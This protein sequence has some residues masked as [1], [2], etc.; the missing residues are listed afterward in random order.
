MNYT[1][2]ITT[3]IEADTKKF[4]RDIDAAG[5]SAK[6]YGRDAK[7]A[8]NDSASAFRKSSKGIGQGLAAINGPLGGISGRFNALSGII[9][10]NSFAWVGF[11][12]A[13]AGA[14]TLLGAATAEFARVERQQLKTQAIL[15]ATGHAVGFS[16][17]E[18]DNQARAIALA[19][20]AST[21]G[22]R[23]AQNALLTFKSVQGSVF[24]ETIKLSQDLADSGFG[25]LKTNAIGLGKAL[26]DP[27][28][29]LTLLTKQGSLTKA[30]QKAI[31]DE[32]KR[33]GDLAAAQATILEAIRKQVGGA[34]GAA[35]GGL[36]GAVDTLGQRWGEM[37]EALADRTGI[38][39]ATTEWLSE[40]AAG[41][42]VLNK[43][44]A[45][46]DT[47]AQLNKLFSDRLAL[48][49]EIAR[50]EERGDARSIAQA[51]RLKKESAV[52]AT[53]LQETGE[54]QEKAR[55]KEFKEYERGQAEKKRLAA[56]AKAA[57]EKELAEAAA[58]EKA[59]Q[60]IQDQRIVDLAKVRFQKIHEEA[61][62]A[63]DRMVQLE[64]ARF[65]T[66]NAKLEADIQKIRDST[67]LKESVKA[68]IEAEYQTRKEERK[69]T[70]EQK[71]AEI[72]KKARDKKISEEAKANSNL[73]RISKNL[74]DS[75]I[76][77]ENKFVATAVKM[78]GILFDVKK[79]EAIKT[80]TMD[81]K[82]AI[83][84]AWASAA[85]PY[86]VPA[87]AL[88]T[89]QTAA[90]IAGIAGIAHGGL[91]NVPAESTFLLQKGER[92]LSPNQN[93]DFTDT[94]KN[95]GL[96]GAPNIN[97]HNYSG[98]P[99]EQQQNG[100][101]IDIFIGRARD[102][103]INDV[104]RGRGLGAAMQERYGLKRKGVA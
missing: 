36:S 9:H 11:G 31:G 15:N 21:E 16:A 1:G 48:Q 58:K 51:G 60:L 3:L 40:V 10:A 24:T 23:D 86:N 35:A 98:Q 54:I 52:L 25:S 28:T 71:I 19:T 8:A 41:L 93:K 90:N 81:G 12:A 79:R 37:L 32:F 103:M 95:G 33:T 14:V 82:L 27:L 50:L 65:E 94:L 6:K 101:D 62:A 45:P 84:K 102:A 39:R 83:Q 18:L 42:G 85:F 75:K 87:V 2:K 29:G 44:V 99:V 26:Q 91:D 30:E 20:L 63:E 78:G 96:G 68:E 17:K 55:Q 97:I 72:E 43:M 13:V 53:R 74:A 76:S 89:G 38:G 7:K 56:E 49:M 88:A 61:L 70:H 47:N 77:S 100:K 57:R 69:Q 46:L 22:V 104:N 66:E 64:Q 34:G 5:K 80:A 73:L 92:I 59:K 67:A 4:G